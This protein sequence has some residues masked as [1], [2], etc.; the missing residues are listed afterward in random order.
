MFKCTVY[1][2]DV[3]KVVFKEILSVIEENNTDHDD[4]AS[5]KCSAL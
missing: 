3:F 2:L 5:G 4:N 1:L